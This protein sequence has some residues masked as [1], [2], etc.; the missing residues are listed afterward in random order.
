MEIKIPKRFE[1]RLGEDLCIECKGVYNKYEKFASTQMYFFPEYTDHSYKHIQ[2]VL[3]TANNLI[4]CDTF[5][6]LNKN[7]IFVLCLSILFHD[8]G[9]HITFKSLKAMYQLNPKDDLLEKNFS[10]LWKEYIEKNKINGELADLEKVDE[11]MITKNI[12]KCGN[13][14]RE[15]HPMIANIIAIEGFPFFNEDEEAAVETYNEK[16]KGYFYKLSGIVARSHGEDLRVM[17]YHL[18]KQYGITWKTP[19]DCHVVYLMCIVRIADYLHITDDRINPYRLNLLDFHS[20][21]SKAEYLKHKSVEYSQRIYGNPEAIYIEANPTDCKI[22]IELIDLLKGI[23]FELDSSWAVLGEVYDV[24]GLKLSIRRVT[25]NILEKEWQQKSNYVADKLKFHFDIRLVDL[26]IEPLY[27]N[28]ASYGIR[29]LIQNATDACKTRKAIYCEQD[30]E[31]KVKVIIEQWEKE[32][33]TGKY[34]KIVDNGIGMSLDV[35][36]NHFLNIG[37]QFRDSNEW[38]NL[39]GRKQEQNELKEKNGKFGVGILSSYLLGDNLRVTTCNVAEQIEYKFETKRDTCLIEINKT[40]KSDEVY[41][42]TIEIDLKDEINIENLVIREWYVSNDVDI[43]IR[44]DEKEVKNNYLIKLGQEDD[45]TD[46]SGEE[47][48]NSNKK[49]WNK[50]ELEKSSLEVYWT[51]DYRIPVMNLQG[52]ND[53]SVTTYRPNLVCNGIVIPKKYDEKNKNSIVSNWPTVYIIDRSGEL[54]LNLSRDEINGNL[55]FIQELESVLLENFMKEYR[56]YGI[57]SKIFAN[58]KMVFSQFNIDNYCN[59]ML[60]FGKRGYVLF[61]RFFIKKLRGRWNGNDKK[62]LGFPVNMFS[63]ESYENNIRIVRI[64]V[65]RN[66]N[67]SLDK[68]LDDNTYYIF[69]KTEEHPNLKKKIVNYL[70]DVP[71]NRGTIYMEKQQLTAYQ[72]YAANTYKL[73]QKF[74]DSNPIKNYEDNSDFCKEILKLNIKK[75]DVS[76]AIVYSSNDLKEYCD[77]SEIF[78]SFYDE[79][80]SVLQCYANLINKD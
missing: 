23:Q 59:Q 77:E 35:I 20:A 65:K 43:E 22:F 67:I 15:Y 27:G 14:I 76:L 78:E 71:F 68:M 6:L 63:G 12:E 34:L 54:D 7:D 44:I 24:S 26:L 18:Q 10:A 41:G 38:N 53:K 52:K 13:F 30:Y 33:K 51:Y 40:P 17:I 19:Y 25:S 47:S 39:S 70:K 3:E 69:E 61:N 1:E 73:S 37:S 75:A 5:E 16:S 28:S 42:T 32:G 79:G 45:E 80:E 4:P 11:S 8:L 2:Y 49:V 57:K 21:K 66:T 9:M 56:E 62:F 36:R 58:D 46:E 74:I 29:E 31:P 50:L 60:M 72:C 48:E 64:W 55:P